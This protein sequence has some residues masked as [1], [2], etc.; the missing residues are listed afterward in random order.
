M[1]LPGIRVTCNLSPL[2]SGKFQKCWFLNM[3]T[4]RVQMFIKYFRR[5]ILLCAPYL[6]LYP[7]VFCFSYTL[8]KP[9]IKRE[10]KLRKKKFNGKK[11][12]A[13]KM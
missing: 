12:G 5:G 8:R 2:L 11:K 13:M 3:L 10:L 7:E 9:D 1:D 6:P 4:I